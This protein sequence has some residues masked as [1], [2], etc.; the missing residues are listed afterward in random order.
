MQALAGGIAIQSTTRARKGTKRKFC[1]LYIA[2]L[3]RQWQPRRSR[4]R[5]RILV[6]RY[7]AACRKKRLKAFKVQIKKRRRNALRHWKDLCQKVVRHHRRRVKRLL[8]VPC[9]G[10]KAKGRDGS[11]RHG[12]VISYSYYHRPELTWQEIQHRNCILEVDDTVC[13]WCK[14]RPKEDLDHAHPACSTKTSTYSWTNALNIFPSCKQCNS[15][16]G[17]RPLAEW[18]AKLVESGLWTRTQIETFQVWLRDNRT[19]LIFDDSDTQYVEEQ[20]RHINAFHALIEHCA[21]YKLNVS[22]FVTLNPI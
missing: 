9:A 13:F 12:L 18:L 1:H 2:R 15:D 21:K 17:G 20:F 16:K 7:A 19:K 11:T 22:D 5:L 8:R 10:T 6:Q 4:W 14:C 3:Y